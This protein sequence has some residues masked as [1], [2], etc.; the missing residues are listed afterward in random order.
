MRTKLHRTRDSRSP[1]SLWKLTE[2]PPYLHAAVIYNHCFKL[3]FGVQF[4]NFLTALQ[5]QPIPKFPGHGSKR[6]KSVNRL[7][8]NTSPG[9]QPTKNHASHDVGLVDSC[10]LAPPFLGG[11]VKCKLCNP[12]RLGSS[13]NLQALDD[14]LCTL[15]ETEVSDNTRKGDRRASPSCLP[16]SWP[17]QF[18]GL[19][20]CSRELYSPSVCS[21]MITR[22]RLLCRVTYPGSDFTWTTLANKSNLRL[23]ADS[24][25]LC[26]RCP[27]PL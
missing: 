12:L 5:E 1:P 18:L 21:R 17:L 7:Q 3:D 13:D 15:G 16:P 6:Q 4:S 27:A 23:R 9:I 24:H 22:S 10:D 8:G 14:T 19:T 25:Q 2:G 26:A 11:I 20:S